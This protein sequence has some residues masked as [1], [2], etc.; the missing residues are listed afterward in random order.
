MLTCESC[1]DRISALF[2]SLT[3]Q[4]VWVE[5]GRAVCC[6]KRAVKQDWQRFIGDALSAGL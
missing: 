3:S 2:H 6:A 1:F 5:T 4:Q